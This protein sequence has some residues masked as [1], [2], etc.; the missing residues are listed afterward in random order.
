[1][2]VILDS[3]KVS[4]VL[5]TKEAERELDR[6][7]DKLDNRRRDDERRDRRPGGREPGERGEERK[8]RGGRGI[9][10]GLFAG[11]RGIT[12]LSPLGGAAA[13]LAAAPMVAAA[14]QQ[15]APEKGGPMGD[16]ILRIVNEVNTIQKQI[17]AI[18]VAG[19]QTVALGRAIQFAGAPQD[20]A[21]LT[22][23]LFAPGGIFEGVTG[24]AQARA[25]EEA[26]RDNLT[27]F[28]DARVKIMIA[29]EL[30]KSP[31]QVVKAAGPLIRGILP[32]AFAGGANQ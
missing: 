16:A 19:Q 22:E 14:L 11:I 24:V 9:A 4:V 25:R 23:A 31:A 3:A 26:A 7:Q 6:L 21:E 13:A 15:I 10:R 32:D 30:I 28:V 29:A 2:S 1:M 5:D 12:G 18:A 17:R 20:E 8:R 27:R